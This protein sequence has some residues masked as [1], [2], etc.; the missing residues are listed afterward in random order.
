[1]VL[2]LSGAGI[3]DST[4]V[5]L[6]DRLVQTCAARGVPVR[7]VAPRRV[8]TRRVLDFVGLT[9]PLVDDDLPSSVS[10]APGRPRVSGPSK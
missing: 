10:S 3:C 5:R 4:G 7:A 2:D 8:P 1:V 9:E 6:L